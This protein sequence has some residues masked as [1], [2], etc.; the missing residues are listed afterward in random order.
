MGRSVLPA[1]LLLAVL[2]VVVHGDS[3]TTKTTTTMTRSALDTVCSSLGGY[4]VTPTL[5]LAAL[6][7][8]ASDPCHAAAVHDAHAVAALAARLAARNATAAQGS[9][10]QSSSAAGADN[11]NATT[12]ASC[13]ELY[14]GA[15]PALRWTAASVAARRYRGAREVIQAT[16]YAAPACEGV[17]EGTAAAAVPPENGQFSDMAF[18][19]HA[20]VAYMAATD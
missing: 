18:V 19:A 16:Q 4:Y 11:N 2:A 20:V 17:M 15:V 5:C 1:L 12:W 3:A 7:S 6:C 8:D 13:L 14:G 9:I 10:I